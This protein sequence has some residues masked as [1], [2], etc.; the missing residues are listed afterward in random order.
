MGYLVIVVHPSSTG[1]LPRLHYRKQEGVQRGIGHVCG[2]PT[3]V[4][5]ESGLSLPGNQGV[6]KLLIEWLGGE[7]TEEAPWGGAA[8]VLGVRESRTH[9]K[10]R[11][12]WRCQWKRT[13]GTRPQEAL[14]EAGT[15]GCCL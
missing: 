14:P 5:G 15:L 3:Y 10:G 11:Q 6:F 7:G 4:S 8:V 2:C 1:V 12:S 13:W 9:G